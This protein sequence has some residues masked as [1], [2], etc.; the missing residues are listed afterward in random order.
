MSD[1]FEVSSLANDSY[2]FYLGLASKTREDVT[3]TQESINTIR[4]RI[5]ED[6]KKLEEDER[7]VRDLEQSLQ[8]LKQKDLDIKAVISDL[9]KNKAQFK[10]IVSNVK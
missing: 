1:K 7:A 8:T 5:T 4:N 2:Q 9:E 3:R 6:K 10:N